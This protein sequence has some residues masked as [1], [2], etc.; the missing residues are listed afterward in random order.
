MTENSTIP[1][2]LIVDDTPANLSL[3]EEILSP[4]YHVRALPNGNLALRAAFN[5]PPDLILLDI[6]MP[7]MDGYEVCTQLKANP[8]TREIPVLFISA[9]QDTEDKL[10]AFKVGGVDYITKP[11]QDAEVLARI[12][13]HLN[14]RTLQQTLLAA[15]KRAEQNA[16]IFARETMDALSLQ[17]CVLDENGILLSVNRAWRTFIDQH[18]LALPDYGIGKNYVTFCQQAV[19]HGDILAGELANRLQQVLAGE[20]NRFEF[21]TT[22]FIQ[23]QQYWFKLDVA[24]FQDCYPTRIV[25][26]HEDITA[27][28]QI[29]TDLIQAHKDAEAAS[30]AKSAFLANMSHELRTPLNAIMGFTHILSDDA[31]VGSEQHEMLKIIQHSGDHLLML[32]NDVL[33]YASI[34]AGRYQISPSETNIH[35]LLE[36]ITQTFAAYCS[37][38]GLAFYVQ[39]SSQIPTYIEIDAK[40][41]RQLLMKLLGNAVKF[42][43]QGAVFLCV[44]YADSVLYIMVRDTGVG[45]APEHHELIFESFQQGNIVCQKPP[46]M[47]MGL[48]ISRALARLMDGDLNMDSLLGQGSTFYLFLPAQAL[49]KS[50]LSTQQDILGYHRIDR[51]EPFQVWVVDDVKEHRE[52]LCNF[53]ISLGFSM[54]PINSGAQCLEML[55]YQRPDLIIMDLKMPGLDGLQTTQKIRAMGMTFPIIAIS[56]GTFP[57]DRNLSLAQGC[58]AYLSKPIE[59]PVLLDAL[60]EFLSLQWITYDLLSIKLSSEQCR[61]L[62]TLVMD[63]NIIELSNY[64]RKLIE[65]PNIKE[66]ANRLLKLAENFELATLQ[67]VV[68][69]LC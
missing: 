30:R 25:I 28:K 60:A 44:N 45:I 14:I 8:K 51:K 18:E 19:S 41:L 50:P 37:Q 4:Y 43:P 42:T 62:Y 23:N 20:Q 40:R 27:R 13:T 6:K 59:K 15:R 35:P 26:A 66:E 17:V 46:G 33:D 38:Q 9:L 12:R 55:G 65:Q 47:G 52:L 64:L 3:L 1:I 61:I 11:F 29:E 24:R 53:L 34:E 5:S 68:K 7:N 67:A 2:L 21:E 49:N 54:N 10:H 36:E 57:E 56:S 16:E 39:I 58:S 63:G 32:L 69:A 22:Y 48:A 31:S